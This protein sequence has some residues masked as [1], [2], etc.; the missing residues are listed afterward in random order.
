MPLSVSRLAQSKKERNIG[1]LILLSRLIQVTNLLKQPG[2]MIICGS[3]W[4]PWKMSISPKPKFLRNR[5]ASASWKVPLL[6]LREDRK[7]SVIFPT[8]VG[9]FINIENK[10]LLNIIV[11]MSLY[12][13][14]VAFY[15]EKT[16]IIPFATGLHYFNCWMWK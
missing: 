13:K 14:Y 9:I 11:T 15:Y 4:N 2:K 16:L 1:D 5:L 12:F 6:S 3:S 7:S 8:L 10:Y